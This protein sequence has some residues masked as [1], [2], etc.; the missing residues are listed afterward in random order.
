MITYSPI[1]IAN[2]FIGLGNRKF[3]L[4]QLLKLSYISHGF[5][6]ATLDKPLSYEMVQA[7][8]FG[9][10]FPSVYHTFK[11]QG[12]GP[13]QN[14]GAISTSP[15]F[16]VIEKKIMTMVYEI[17]GNL[18]GLQLSYITHREKTPWHETWYEGNNS[19]SHGVTIDNE[20]IKT[21]FQEI[22]RKYGI[23]KQQ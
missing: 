13:I 12:Y 3:D 18:N 16:Q 1:S 22:I 11:S 4:M 17:Y 6:L 14:N 8:K 23:V 2:H 10:V 5:C 21:H 15:D 19:Q 7:W 20:I 9:P